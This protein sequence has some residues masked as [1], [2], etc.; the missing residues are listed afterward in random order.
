[1]EIKTCSENFSI[2]NGFMI[3]SKRELDTR[4]LLAC[5]QRKSL[6]CLK[7]TFE[8]KKQRKILED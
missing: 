3:S 5:T 7:K 2:N 6:C 4:I 8:K 1:M